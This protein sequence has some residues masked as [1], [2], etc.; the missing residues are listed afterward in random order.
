VSN[1][2]IQGSRLRSEETGKASSDVV[3]QFHRWQ[4]KDTELNGRS[5]R[6]PIAAAVCKDG[7]IVSIQASEFSYCHPRRTADIDYCSFEL[8]FPNMDVPELA[9]WKDGDGDDRQ[10]VYGY[11]PVETIVALLEKHGGLI[12]AL[13]YFHREGTK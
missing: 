12:G 1:E 11:V 8:G 6:K 2:G 7:F 10:S 3:N 13:S 5:Y 4:R 9:E